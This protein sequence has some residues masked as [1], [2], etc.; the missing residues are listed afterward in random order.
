MA[1]IWTGR[2]KPA[3]ELKKV[4]VFHK[5]PVGIPSWWQHYFSIGGNGSSMR[6]L[7]RVTMAATK[8]RNGLRKNSA[9]DMAYSLPDT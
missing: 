3:L 7:V 9:A 6:M 2:D 4:P 1:L 5:S 8:R